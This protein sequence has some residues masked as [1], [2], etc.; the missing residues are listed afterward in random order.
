MSRYFV[1]YYCR[2]R[3]YK[4][5]ET[6]SRFIHDIC[7]F[8]EGVCYVLVEVASEGEARKFYGLKE[9]LDLEGG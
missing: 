8:H 5:C 6:V 2:D 9:T 3:G 4:T 7:H 1:C